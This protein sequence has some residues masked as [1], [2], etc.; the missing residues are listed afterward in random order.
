MQLKGF[1]PLLKGQCIDHSSDWL[2]PTKALRVC[3]FTVHSSSTASSHPFSITLPPLLALLTSPLTS[4]LHLYTSPLQWHT[5]SSPLTHP[6][7]PEPPPPTSHLSL[8]LPSSLSSHHLHL[9]L[10]FSL[11]IHFSSAHMSG[12]RGASHGGSG[13][14]MNHKDGGIKNFPTAPLQGW[15]AWL[16]P[17]CASFPSLPPTAKC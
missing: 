11:I 4:P 9:F 6:P 12:H 15:P 8:L 14:Q 7:P 10:S 13:G 2:L 3:L 16:K 17:V 1:F 5:A